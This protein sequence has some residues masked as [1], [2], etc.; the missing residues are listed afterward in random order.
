MQ[1]HGDRLLVLGLLF[2]LL[3]LFLRR[4]RPAS[5]PTTR[6][7]MQSAFKTPLGP[8]NISPPP[9]LTVMSNRSR[10]RHGLDT[11]PAAALP[12]RGSA[13]AWDSS[14]LGAS[15]TDQTNHG[16]M[17]AHLSPDDHI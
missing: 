13:P 8:T 2:L 17:P 15:P 16:E 5:S 4:D 6:V 9:R 7:S 14:S 3:F 10:R 1:R 12:E 11:C